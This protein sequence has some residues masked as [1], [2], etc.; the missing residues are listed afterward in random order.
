MGISKFVKETGEKSSLAGENA[1]TVELRV[2][3]SHSERREEAEQRML[4]AAV[5][6]VAERGLEE[7]TLA[8]CGQAAG[9]S[10]GLAAH[11]FGCKE[12]LIAA[13][14][15]HIVTDYG[16]RQQAGGRSKRGLQGLLDAVSFYI[17]SGSRN[18]KSVRAFHA[19]LGS[20]LKQTKLSAAIA[21]LNNESIAA[22]AGAM[23]DGIAMGEIRSDVNP[24]A[25]GALII[26]A[27]RG[28]IS[29]WL[30]D[31]TTD[32]EAI[33]IELLNNLRHSLAR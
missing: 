1:V 20:S 8:E 22:F 19:V 15:T 11:Y 30:L 32:L 31:P 25:Q 26:A 17:E 7:L 24:T 27:L 13:I 33:R 4:E 29:Q 14:A 18:L 9:Y 6:I 21:R 3:R 5:D 2:R 23:R 28:V 10:R 16:R 12:D